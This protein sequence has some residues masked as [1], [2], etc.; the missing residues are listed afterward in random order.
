[1]PL[2]RLP[3]GGRTCKRIAE[4]L[5]SRRAGGFGQTELLRLPIRLV[6]GQALKAQ[7]R[8]CRH[9]WIFHC[10]WPTT[11]RPKSAWKPIRFFCS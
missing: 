10:N 8:L 9:G 2:I 4:R 7:K 1:M 11:G 3:S 5:R 6:I